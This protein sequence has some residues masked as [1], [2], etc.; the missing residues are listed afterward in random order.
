M[1]Q[2]QHVNLTHG[3][4]TN[5]NQNTQE[6][7]PQGYDVQRLSA[8]FD[9]I[10]VENQE[11][12]QW[13]AKKFSSLLYHANDLSQSLDMKNISMKKVI[14]QSDQYPKNRRP[15]TAVNRPERVQ[16][17]QQIANYQPLSNKNSQLSMTQNP[18]LIENSSYE[19]S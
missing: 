7:G 2:M 12:E 6:S 15:S 3:L 14:Q 18:Y 11:Q 4:A 16:T 8:N 1:Q 5:S 17:Q 10:A 19:S 9:M 13:V